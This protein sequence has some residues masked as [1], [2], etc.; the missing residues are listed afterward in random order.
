MANRAD[1]RAS[2]KIA[3]QSVK[4]AKSPTEGAILRAAAAFASEGATGQ[5]RPCLSNADFDDAW[6]RLADDLEDILGEGYPDFRAQAYAEAGLGT[7]RVAEAGGAEVELGTRLVLC[8]VVGPADRVAAFADD[9]GEIARL[10]TS[11]REAGVVPEDGRCLV[12]PLVVPI[13]AFMPDASPPGRVRALHEYLS[14]RLKDGLL[15]TPL[16]SPDAIRVA[17]AELLQA[18]PAASGGDTAFGALVGI[19]LV[20]DAFA[21]RTAVPED[22]LDAE[23][24][25]SAAAV[26]SWYDSYAADLADMAIGAPLDW[27]ACGAA[28]AWE[29]VRIPMEAALRRRGVPDGRPETI[30]CAATA[31]G[32]R[33]VLSAVTGPI[34]VGPFSASTDLAWFDADEFFGRVEAN[35]DSLV[36]HDDEGDVVA[37]LLGA[38]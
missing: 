9:A 19:E 24:L 29:T 21:G 13:A 15:R 6:T 8:P 33:L 7:L 4:R 5:L 11:L 31:D 28:L 23:D 1:R 35:A 25:A 20:L 22:E 30:H 27:P 26:E 37:P 34:A 17:V 32:E 2:A 36:E 3:R 10:E 38:A 18:D 16:P 14:D 12:L